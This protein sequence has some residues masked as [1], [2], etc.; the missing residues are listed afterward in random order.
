V[1]SASWNKVTRGEYSIIED[2]AGNELLRTRGSGV[3][4]TDIRALFDRPVKP[5][6]EDGALFRNFAQLEPTT[7]AIAEFAN[8]YGLLWDTEVGV[9]FWAWEFEIRTM[10]FLIAV[11]DAIAAKE[12]EVLN[13]HFPKVR[14][15]FKF[16]YVDSVLFYSRR[17]APPQL[18]HELEVVAHE[19]WTCLGAALQ[20]LIM[21]LNFRL[22]EPGGLVKLRLKQVKSKYGLTHGLVLTLAP[23]ELLSAMW[24]QFAD[25]IANEKKYRQCEACWRYMELSP[26][27]NRADRIYCSDACR[28]KALRRRQKRA[29]EMRDEN[30]SLREI[31]METG[32]D[33]DTIKQWLKPKEHR[34]KEK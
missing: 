13:K 8:R 33:I 20:Y 4:Y 1:Q 11:W 2:M 15:K 27:K 23:A 26:D 30:R 31:S 22:Q 10:R 9:P 28:N 18:V 5:T 14:G 6:A 17:G 12:T 29:R 19:D 32:S 34:K 24:Y 21:S 3:N 16:P 25:S 7:E